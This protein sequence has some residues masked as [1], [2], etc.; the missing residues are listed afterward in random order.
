LEISFL[1]ALGKKWKRIS[2][3]PQFLSLMIWKFRTLRA[4]AFKNARSIFVEG[5]TGGGF[6]WRVLIIKGMEV[7][8]FSRK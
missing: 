8:E 4:N 1:L 5:K 3:F 6:C 7:I 2:F